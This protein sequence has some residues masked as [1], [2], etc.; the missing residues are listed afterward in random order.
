MSSFWSFSLLHQLLI[1][2]IILFLWGIV[3]W[4]W[5]VVSVILLSAFFP[6]YFGP[7]KFAIYGVPFTLIEWMIY[8][9]F[10]V[11]LFR[12]FLL[13]QR[14][15]EGFLIQFRRRFFAV[16]GRFSVRGDWRRSLWT[17]IV[18]IFIGL[19]LPLASSFFE[20]SSL[21]SIDRRALL[22]I[23][24]GWFVAPL[25]YFYLMQHL[26]PGLR[27]LRRCLEWYTIS[28]VFLSVWGI[29]QF[30]FHLVTT[31]DGRV[32]GPFE[33]ANYLALYIMPAAVFVLMR[34]WHIFAI[35]REYDGLIGLFRKIFHV[36]ETYSP[37]VLIR[38]GFFA[39]ILL[40]TLY[41]TRS[42]GALLGLSGALFG[43]GVYHFFF[44]YWK[45]SFR[46][47]FLWSSCVFLALAVVAGVFLMMGDRGKFTQAF[48]FSGRSSSSVRL[49]VWHVAGELI[50]RNFFLGLGAGQFERHYSLSSGEILGVEPY[51]KTMLHPHNIFLMFWL[52]SGLIGLVGFIWLLVLLFLEVGR[53]TRHDG[54]KRM[55]LTCLVMLSAI[56]LHGLVDTPIWK[57][58]LALQF[59]MIAGGLASLRKLV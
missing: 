46:K 28:A 50:G 34:L 19:L 9:S 35:P 13:W 17:P 18:L 30:V 44:S 14:S 24:K 33:S 21:A 4:G 16:R 6:F 56:L 7:V 25:M 3:S 52:S 47:A 59:W 43:Y 54:V 11:Y 27:A 12:S 36:E 31:P 57:N 41:L 20:G 53:L 15:R 26:L 40:Y 8:V 22:G 39:I 58:D 1:P 48:N 51:E 42:F 55:G 23:V 38:Y 29:M 49:Q 5:P 10:L 37:A 45:V 2:G 32:S